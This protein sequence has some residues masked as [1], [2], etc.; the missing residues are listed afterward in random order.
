MKVII[1]STI[2]LIA[3]F[4][5]AQNFIDR[6]FDQYEDL[7]ETTVVHVTAKSFELASFVL[8]DND[9]EAKEMKDFIASVK[10]LDLIAVPD[11]SNASAEY[12]RGTSILENNFEEL[13]NIKD[14]SSR[15]SLFIDEENDIVYELVGIGIDDESKLFV[16]SITGEMDLA[17][18]GSVINNLESGELKPFKKMKDYDA[19]AFKIYPNPV[20]SKTTLTVEIPESMIGGNGTVIDFKGAAV[21]NFKISSSSQKIDTN[22][23]SPGTYIISLE[24]EGVNIKKQVVVVK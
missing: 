15:F 10:S 16:V 21:N 4:C 23:L 11:L 24:K 2:L 17:I 12:K 6:H 7:D 3:T 18:I 14:K 9:E 5:S 19:G 1:T 13:M 8:P 20:G 22:A